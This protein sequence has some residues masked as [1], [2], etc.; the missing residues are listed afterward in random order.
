MTVPTA[1]P[2][3]GTAPVGVPA[4]DGPV[5]EGQTPT[6]AFALLLAALAGG[7]AVPVP[8]VVVPQQPQAEQAPTDPAG[9]IGAVAAPASLPAASPV[10][11]EA[12]TQRSHVPAVDAPAV[13][14]PTAP[15]PPALGLDAPAPPSSATTTTAATAATATAATT[16]VVAPGRRAPLQEEPAPAAVT[17]DEPTPAAP[18]VP[19]TTA[20]ASAAPVV[21]TA[22]AVTAATATQPIADGPAP[23]STHRVQPAVLEAARG[24]RDEGGGRTSLVVRL[25]PPELGAVV[26]R[27]TVQDGRV[28]VQLRTPDVSARGD[29]QAQS[30]DV[31][32]VLRDNGFDLTSFD[33]S[34]GDVPSGNREDAK[35]PDRGTPQRQSTADGHAGNPRV[36]D[37]VTDPQAAGTWL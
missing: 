16:E 24:L 13:P 3:P 6:D 10:V 15:A 25:D 4:V 8:G 21:A 27:L 5:A 12:T 19:E 18:L 36:T 28:D 29:L 30:F 9:A 34:H 2:L 20:P 22:A 32:R 11:W 1:L 26:V 7:I 17:L 14:G 35:T 31:Q 37:D 23:A 33:V